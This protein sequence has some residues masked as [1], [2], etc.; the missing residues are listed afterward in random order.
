MSKAIKEEKKFRKKIHG[1]MLSGI[2]KTTRKQSQAK[3]ITKQEYKKQF[4]RRL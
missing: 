2:Q 1:R 3:K 4:S